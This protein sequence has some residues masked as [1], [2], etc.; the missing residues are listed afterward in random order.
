MGVEVV[1]GISR[2]VDTCNVYVLSQGRRALLIELGDAGVLGTV[3]ASSV[4]FVLHTHFHRDLT[5]GHRTLSEPLNVI[6]PLKEVEY[7]QSAE[8]AWQGREIFTRYDL[9]NE[10][11]S[12]VRNIPVQRAVKE[13]DVIEWQGLKLVV[14]DT[15]GHSQGSVSYLCDLGGKRVLFSGDLIYS[16]GRIWTFYD[17][18]WDYCNVTGLRATLDTI[19]KLEEEE[20]DIILP[21]HGEPIEEPGEALR[22]LKE[23]LEH[24]LDLL[25][26]RTGAKLET[27]VGVYRLTPHLVVVG[28]SISKLLVS[29]SGMALAF[30]WGY[31]PN[32]IL[33]ELKTQLGIERIQAVLFSHYHDDHIAQSAELR[34]HEGAEIWAFENMLDILEHP[35]RY[36]LP[37]LWREPLL[38]DRVLRDGERIYWEGLDLRCFH[39][40]GQTEYSMG[41]FLLDGGKRIL[42]TGDNIPAPREGAL[43]RGQ[44]CCRNHQTLGEGYIKSAKL[45]LQLQPELLVGSH[46]EAFEVTREQ[47]E[48]HL[49]WAEETQRAVAELVEQPA[50]E[51]G[52][53]PLWATFYPYQVTTA[54]EKPF[55]TELR[56]RNYLESPAELRAELRFPSHWK[57]QPP[58]VELQLDPRS[59]CAIRFTITP[60]L[61]RHPRIA[62]TAD[63]TLNGMRFGEIAEGLVNFEGIF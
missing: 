55:Q 42:L 51:F 5:Q 61:S 8:I 44:F 45:M 35:E 20:I 19:R 41:L 1:S 21:A 30:D 17:L 26:W 60:S 12:P 53:D 14:L 29:D 25:D 49:E 23:K 34:L 38:V 13:G 7:F 47:L 28:G 4:D 58:G 63:I 11:F 2:F 54:T 46:W 56:V 3:E 52:I 50:P 48:E 27:N 24:A 32:G 57:A 62:Y 36:N 9:R 22:Q 31:M 37:C 6:A 43:L 18:E 16:A 59:E 40:P 15:P 39:L 10:F 33:E